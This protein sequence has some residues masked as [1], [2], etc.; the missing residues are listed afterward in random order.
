[1]IN[2][3]KEKRFIQI[4]N[5]KLN[6][7]KFAD[8]RV[9]VSEFENKIQSEK[10]KTVFHNCFFNTIDTTTYFEEDGSVYIITGDIPAMWLRDSSVQ[11]MQYLFFAKQCPS[12]R[13]YIKGVL[14]K[15]FAFILL[16]PYAN[17]FNREANGKGHITDLDPQHPHVWER[18]FELDSLCYPL[19]L[20]VKYFE[21]TKDK[22]CFENGF[23]EAFDKCIEI[24]K[25]EQN[26]ANNSKYYHENVGEDKKYWV[27]H[28][29]PVANNGL[30]WSGY[31]PSDDKCSYGYYLPGNMFIVS[32]LTKLISIFKEELQ[33]E[34]R[35]N[36]CKNLSQEIQEAL[37]KYAIVKDEDGNKIYALETDGLGNYNM[38]DDANVPNLL[39]MP[40]YEYP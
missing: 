17:A 10:L 32:V 1:M 28:G 6:Q 25:I 7:D 23:L 20:A 29:D 38:M 31:R 12:V 26:H 4:L 36:I 27:G 39:S 22:A 13:E 16:D 8:L 11:V 15:Q 40:Y 9:Q 14:T 33:D 3:E 34:T 5:N 19:Y 2:V 18:K 30:V 21:S 37:D 24:F 35:S